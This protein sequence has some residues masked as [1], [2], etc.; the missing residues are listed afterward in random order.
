MTASSS[1]ARVWLITGSSSGFGRAIA[2]A[3]LS[4]GEIVVLTA[5]NTQQVEDIVARF[6]D[7]ALA[8]RLDVTRP[9]EVRAAM[10]KAIATFGHIDVLV[11]ETAGIPVCLQATG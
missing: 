8:V 11:K 7:R 5:R 2:D 1:N 9:D 6:P 10:E 3:V 4:R